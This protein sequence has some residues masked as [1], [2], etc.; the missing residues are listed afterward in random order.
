MD[1]FLLDTMA[2]LSI[3]MDTNLNNLFI[4]SMTTTL[5]THIQK[6][7]SMKGTELILLLT[8]VTD[9]PFQPNQDRDLNLIVS[10]NIISF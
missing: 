4:N 5:I 8:M 3:H 2:R 9:M 10:I 7:I 6:N 1:T